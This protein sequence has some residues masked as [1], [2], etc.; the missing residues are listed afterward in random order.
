MFRLWSLKRQRK[1]TFDFSIWAAY[2]KS[3]VQ[4][5]TQKKW[6]NA[7]MSG[8]ESTIIYAA[9]ALLLLITASRFVLQELIALVRL[10]KQLITEIR[11]PLPA[12]QQP[13]ALPETR[14]KNVSDLAA[15]KTYE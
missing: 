1:I 13:V 8:H 14:S 10:V 2:F 15:R 3:K 5:R 9:A 11:A 12:A 6:R 4:T 7:F